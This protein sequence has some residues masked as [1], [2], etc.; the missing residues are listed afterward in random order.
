MVFQK[1]KIKNSEVL[2]V[3]MVEKFYLKFMPHAHPALEKC[4][5]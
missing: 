5:K 3:F 2:N 4:R 1:K